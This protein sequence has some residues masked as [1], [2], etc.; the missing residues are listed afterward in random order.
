MPTLSVSA[1]LRTVVIGLSGLVVAAC[2]YGSWSSWQ[3]VRTTNTIAAVAE[4]TQYLFTALP[5]SM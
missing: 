3:R 2:A 1:T 5:Q 4:A